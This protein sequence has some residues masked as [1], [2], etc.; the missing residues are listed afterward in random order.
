MIN[1]YGIYFAGDFAVDRF[2]TQF[3]MG[4]GSSLARGHFEARKHFFALHFLS[5]PQVLD[6]FV[7]R[8]NQRAGPRQ[9]L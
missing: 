1:G 5:S 8:F 2:V 6:G 9:V 3:H 4:A 7:D